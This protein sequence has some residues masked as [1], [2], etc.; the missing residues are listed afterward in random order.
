[1]RRKKDAGDVLYRCDLLRP[2]WRTPPLSSQ[3]YLC[4]WRLDKVRGGFKSRDRLRGKQMKSIAAIQGA[5]LLSS[6]TTA[7]VSCSPA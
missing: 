3:A 4:R 2:S 1:M 6:V 7:S 5:A